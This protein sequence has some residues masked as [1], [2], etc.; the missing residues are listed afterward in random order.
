MK[1]RLHPD[2]RPHTIE[3]VGQDFAVNTTF[4]CRMK[5]VQATRNQPIVIRARSAEVKSHSVSSF[6]QRTDREFIREIEP[7]NS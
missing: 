3:S 1:N 5:A 6:L 4:E 2:G 7:T